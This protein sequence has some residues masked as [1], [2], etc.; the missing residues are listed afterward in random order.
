[1]SFLL[2]FI[3][4]LKLYH[5]EPKFSHL[6]TASSA[7]PDQTTI[8]SSL[9]VNA[10][11]RVFENLDTLWFFLLLSKCHVLV[12]HC[13]YIVAI[14]SFASI[15]F[16]VI[17]PVSA[18]ALRGVALTRGRAAAAIAARGVYGPAAA[19][20]LQAAAIR[21]P[22]AIPTATALPYAT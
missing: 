9:F 7:D 22:G 11:C 10:L 18:A 12:E 19:A 4:Q 14:G 5:K 6:Y 13:M 2:G 8:G 17:S 3:I 1:M 16:T 20:Q 15:S 21:H